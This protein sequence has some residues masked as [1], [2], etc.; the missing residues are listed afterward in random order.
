MSAADHPRVH[1]KTTAEWR[2]WLRDNHATAR[3]VWLV[4]YKAATG[5]A[6]LS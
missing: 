3:G 4:A 1:P 5:K 6:R 2:R